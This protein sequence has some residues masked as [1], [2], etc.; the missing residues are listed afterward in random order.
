MLL[1]WLGSGVEE[2][3]VAVLEIVPE[4]FGETTARIKR[5]TVE[6]LAMLPR[7]YGEL[8]GS[9]LTP[10]FVEI[11]ADES[12]EGSVSLSKTFSA[13]LGPALDIEI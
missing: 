13:V 1:D 10:P 4:A 2:L 9:Q 5:F 8:Q 6:L 3:T 12:D 7:E 11:W